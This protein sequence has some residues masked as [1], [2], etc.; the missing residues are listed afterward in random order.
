MQETKRVGVIKNVD[1]NDKVVEF[2]APIYSKDI[3]LLEKLLDKNL[4]C[5]KKSWLEMRY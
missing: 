2:L 1:T 4:D 5:L 3:D